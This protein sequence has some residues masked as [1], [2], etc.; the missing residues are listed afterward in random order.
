MKSWKTT[1]CGCVAAAA[2]GIALDESID[3]KIRG[4]AKMVGIA[5]GALLGYFARDNN[6]TSE[7]VGAK[8]D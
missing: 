4:I 6:V 2:A 8:K 7:Q 5:A 1:V 3:P